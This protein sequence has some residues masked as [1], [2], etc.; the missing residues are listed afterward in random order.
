MGAVLATAAPATVATVA[1][2]T[3]LTATTKP[4]ATPTTQLAFESARLLQQRLPIRSGQH[5]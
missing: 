5:L 1:T 4:A 2:R 3:T